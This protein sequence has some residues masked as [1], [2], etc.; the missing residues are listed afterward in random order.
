MKKV[1]LI[2]ACAVI[3]GCAFEVEKDGTTKEKSVFIS[4]EIR[5]V[6]GHDYMIVTHHNGGVCAL[7]AASCQCMVQKMYSIEE[8]VTTNRIPDIGDYLMEA[9]W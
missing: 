8:L 1:I 3:A 6:R 9:K 2:L 5:T 4:V 7:H